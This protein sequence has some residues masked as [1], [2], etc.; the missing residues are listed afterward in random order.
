MAE[1]IE[2]RAM[3]DAEAVKHFRELFLWWKA[4][5]ES[6][7]RCAHQL[8]TE[9]D[10]AWRDIHYLVNTIEVTAEM[11]GEGPD[12]E[13]AVLVA[14][15]KKDTEERLSYLHELSTLTP[16]D[17]TALRNVLGEALSATAEGNGDK[18]P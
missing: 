17:V 16:S 8:Q 14:Q 15:I 11:I 10:A 2:V 18:A 6:A 9:R 7:E 5:A 1:E 3:T 13:D 12:G 4:K